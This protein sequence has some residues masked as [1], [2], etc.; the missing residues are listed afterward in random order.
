MTSGFVNFLAYFVIVAI[1][2]F[3]LSHGKDLTDASSALFS[4]GFFAIIVAC[5]GFAM[6]TI[7][8]PLPTLAVDTIYYSAAIIAAVLFFVGSTFE[9]KIIEAEARIGSVRLT[10][11]IEEA[12][13]ARLSSNLQNAQFKLSNLERAIKEARE[14]LE[15]DE[16]SDLIDREIEV[17]LELERRTG[18]SKFWNETD[19]V[20]AS[21]SILEQRIEL[22]RSINPQAFGLVDPFPLNDDLLSNNFSGS[23]GVFGRHD[24]FPRLTDPPLTPESLRNAADLMNDVAA[25]SSFRMDHERVSKEVAGYNRLFL[26]EAMRKSSGFSRIV[27]TQVTRLYDDETQRRISLVSELRNAQDLDAAAEDALERAKSQVKKASESLEDSEENKASIQSGL[28]ELEKS[29]EEIKGQNLI[30]LVLWAKQQGAETWPFILIAVLGMKLA[31][32]SLFF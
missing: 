32:K 14:F 7:R 31:R 13:T 6:P 20:L 18:L 15:S 25:C 4:I 11:K 29:L 21:C 27:D 19:A 1:A 23:N 30:G 22:E 3:F 2:W 28:E 12:E 17:A 26:L 5:V 16:A 9:R 24:N 10:L 8:A